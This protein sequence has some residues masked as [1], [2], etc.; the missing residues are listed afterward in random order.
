MPKTT[1][2]IYAETDRECPVLD[3]LDG[4]PAKARD[5]CYVRVERLSEM[6]HELRRPEADILER[7]IHE[8]RARL[9][10]VQYRILYFFHQQTAVLSHGFIKEGS[11]VPMK[12]IE[13]AL[14]RKKAFDV[15]PD[16]H[17]H[18]E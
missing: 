17:T 8:L 14:R 7:G 15:D 3:W 5:K 1:V 12:E 2:V 11:E 6:G 4:L 13:L 10:T 18:K 16:T 9:G